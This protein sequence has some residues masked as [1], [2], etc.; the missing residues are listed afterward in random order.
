MSIRIIS[1]VS[2][3]KLKKIVKIIKTVWDMLV[4]KS[5]KDA[6]RVDSLDDNFSLDNIDRIT[7]IFY[8]FKE[9]TQQRFSEIEKT[10]K[11]EVEFYLDEIKWI[12]E[13]NQEITEKYRI[14]IG[15]IQKRIDCILPHL[16]GVIEREISKKISL[17]N[18]ECR[19]IMKM[20]PGQNKE[21]ALQ[22]FINSV[23]CNALDLCCVNMKE[24]LE[25]I[26]E[27]VSDE[28][29]GIV[30]LVQRDSELQLEQLKKI[31]EDNCIEGKIKIL[32]NAY[33]YIS[34]C[35]FAEEILRGV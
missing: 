30:E 29:I 32:S 16:E 18:S 13:E 22:N 24:N 5:A 6:S 8:D 35:E 4:N 3:E 9:Q 2:K 20:I 27:E 33:Y 7:G 23:V 21:I 15:R 26:Y 25:E 12:L 11:E 31:H 14:R 28:I 19:N 34:V 1:P 17:D 10:I